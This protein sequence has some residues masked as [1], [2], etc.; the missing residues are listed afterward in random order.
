[1]HLELVYVKNYF[2]HAMFWGNS[3]WQQTKQSAPGKNRGLLWWL[4][5]ANHVKFTFRR[6]LDVYGEACFS[7][8]Y[9]SN[10]LNFGLPQLAR[11]EKT[12]HRI[13]IHSLVKKMFWVQ[14][15]VKK[16]LLTVFWGMKGPLTI[17]FLQKGCNCKERFL[18]LKQNSS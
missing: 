16:I 8:K 6:M 14:Q 3:K 17:D 5:S 1:M 9:L 12:V 4:R 11:I 2:N 15:S 13:E 10:G 18:L 7:L